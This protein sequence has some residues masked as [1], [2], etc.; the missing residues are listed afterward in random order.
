MGR[1]F[2]KGSRYYFEILLY[3][4]A[5]ATIVKELLTTKLTFTIKVKRISHC[6]PFAD[7]SAKLFIAVMKN[8]IIH[9]KI[10][11][12]IAQVVMFLI[13]LITKMLAIFIIA[14]ALL[15]E[16]IDFVLNRING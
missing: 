7:S 12:R 14:K 15:Q 13:Q 9:F 8:P 10:L 2:L 3:S 5:T 4:T 6:Q 1:D 16:A 11:P